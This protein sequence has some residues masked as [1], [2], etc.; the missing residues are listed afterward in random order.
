MTIL[1]LNPAIPVYVEKYDR[2]PGGNGY[3][4]AIID[5]SAE[6]N[7]MWVVFLDESR[8]CWTVPNMRIRIQKN[9]SLGR[10]D[11]VIPF[12]V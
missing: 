5:Y 12:S 11:N 3:A 1:Q 2:C 4:H 9:I 7:L 6:H 8:E 10:I